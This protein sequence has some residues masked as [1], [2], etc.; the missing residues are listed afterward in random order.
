MSK[1]KY[2]I[3]LG[4]LGE[5]DCLVTYDFSPAEH[6]IGVWHEEQVEITGVTLLTGLAISDKNLTQ[7]LIDHLNAD[8]SLRDK[9]IEKETEESY[10]E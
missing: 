10:D 6:I 8:E 4:P 7:T 2:W 3:E 1:I 5:V 9:I